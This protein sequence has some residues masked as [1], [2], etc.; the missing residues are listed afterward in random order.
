MPTFPNAAPAIPLRN[1]WDICVVIAVFYTISLLPVEAAY[2]MFGD[3]ATTPIPLDIAVDAIL[4]L[5]IIINFRT[6]VHAYSHKAHQRVLLHEG[7]EVKKVSKDQ[8]HL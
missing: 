1:R 8:L 4:F 5:D 3:V 2:N 7:K 6:V